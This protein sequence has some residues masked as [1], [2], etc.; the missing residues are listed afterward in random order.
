M[1]IH[2]KDH[3]QEITSVKQFV[4]YCERII[5]N[6]TLIKSINNNIS[7]RGSEAIAYFEAF[8]TKNLSENASEKITKIQD[9][10][11]KINE[12]VDREIGTIINSVGFPGS[13][14]FEAI[15]EKRTKEVVTDAEVREM[16]NFYNSIQKYEPIFSKYIND[17]F[18][19]E[20]IDKDINSYT[21][22]ISEID[23]SKK[24]VGDINTNYNEF[25]E[26]KEE[27]YINLLDEK[28]HEFNEK[29]KVY[30]ESFEKISKAQQDFINYEEPTKLWEK[31]STKNLY[32]F[33]GLSF[34]TLVVSIVLLWLL[35]DT[36]LPYYM[37][38]DYS[39]DS[40]LI[41]VTAS[42]AAIFSV[43]LFFM[44][45]LFKI[46]FTFFN[47]YQDANERA[48]LAKTFYSLSKDENLKDEERKI[49]IQALFS[50]TESGLLKHQET[51][52]PSLM[53]QIKPPSK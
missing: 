24:I 33:M 7:S 39:K 1:K 25:S 10:E 37:N 32:W 51:I 17:K 34:M 6:K 3:T 13:F 2:F 26:K 35:A 30:E 23:S 22:I 11:E 15:S 52:L 31:R 50:R 42:L 46:T 4:K 9:L 29:M 16:V 19:S 38:L 44:M 45:N 28:T 20:K 47:L 53:N 43:L 18:I 40:N 36:I 5:E 8:Y 41:K 49:I 48:T 12:R 14:I 27:E 21:E